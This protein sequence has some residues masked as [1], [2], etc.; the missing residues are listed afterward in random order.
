M[1]FTGEKGGRYCSEPRRWPS[2]LPTITR[3]G[4]RPGQMEIPRAREGRGRPAISWSKRRRVRG[5]PERKEKPRGKE[6]STTWGPPL[7]NIQGAKG[8]FVRAAREGSH[9]WPRPKSKALATRGITEWCR[10]PGQGGP[11]SG[12]QGRGPEPRDD[13]RGRKRVPYCQWQVLVFR[14]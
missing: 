9:R 5:Y 2:H 8:G 6:E 10:A 11:C 3:K 1:M 12:A 7:G 4:N 14:R 13:S